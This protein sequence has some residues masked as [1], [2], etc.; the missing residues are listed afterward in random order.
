MRKFEAGLSRYGYRYA[1]LSMRA[2][3][4]CS[5]AVLSSLKLLSS[6]L[7]SVKLGPRSSG[8]RQRKLARSG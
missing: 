7:L 5:H 3:R 6:T 1:T 2:F 8:D 4:L